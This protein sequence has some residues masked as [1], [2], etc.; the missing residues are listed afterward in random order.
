MRYDILNDAFEW[1]AKDLAYK[2]ICYKGGGG[3]GTPSTTT[4]VQKSEPPA[5]QVPYL[6]KTMGQAEKWYD[7]GLN[8]AVWGSGGQQTIAG[9]TPEQTLAQ[10]GTTARA[11]LGSP[12]LRAGSANLFDTLSGTYLNPETNP[13]AK[14]YAN[15]MLEESGVGDADAAAIKAGRYGGD[16]WG[17]MR[18]KTLADIG[19]QLYDFE[20]GNQ[21]QALGL[22]PQY[23]E[24]DYAD[25]AKLAA[26][27]ETKQAYDQ[28]L[29]DEQKRILLESD[30]YY[31]ELNRIKELSNLTQGHMGQTS[32]GSQ[33]TPYYGT[34]LS[35]TLLGGGMLGLGTYGNLKNWGVI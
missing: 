1:S 8:P 26:V 15:L 29:L 10:E 31:R 11:M 17:L 23:A 6:Q 12:V 7:K 28:A 9:F 19:T 33:T 35:S 25:L 16:A 4:T 14:N 2:H 5:W 30:P 18:G 13:Y 3:G 27:G 20:R 21:M 22:A 34:P 32:T 24:T